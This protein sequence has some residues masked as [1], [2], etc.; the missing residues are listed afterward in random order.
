MVKVKFSVKHVLLKVF[1][2]VKW[3]LGPAVKKDWVQAVANAKLLAQN[4]L[5]ARLLQSYPSNLAD[6]SLAGSRTSGTL[7]E[8]CALKVFFSKEGL[9]LHDHLLKKGAGA[10]FN[11]AVG[12]VGGNAH[13]HVCQA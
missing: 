9:H 8:W 10:D 13:Q 11:G 6:R 5:P 7:P 3:H 2:K 1:S 4:G 12:A